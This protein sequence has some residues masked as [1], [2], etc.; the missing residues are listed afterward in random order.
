MGN[1]KGEELKLRFIWANF[2]GI[3]ELN[4]EIEFPK[5]KVVVLYG[6]NLQGKTNL[7]NAI[8]F[9]FLRET[10]RGRKK[11][12]YDDWALPT[13]E[14]IVANGKANIDVVFEHNGAYYKLNREI[15]AGGRKDV[16]TLSM[17]TGW[18]GKKIKPVDF[19][20]FVKERLKAG[21]LDALFAPEIAG[22]FKHLYGRNIDEAITEVFKEVISARQLSRRFI[23]RFEK[24]KSGAEAETTT[25]LEA[26]NNYCQE[27]LAQSKALLRFP[28]FR[29]FKKFTPGK[30]FE[31][32]TKLLEATRARIKS[33]E[34]DE[35]F[36]YLNDMLQKS[37]DLLQLRKAFSEEQKVKDLL[38]GIKDVNSDIEHLRTLLL[39][40]QQVATVEDDI[41]EPPTFHDIE[42]N[43]KA[44][45][46]YKRLVEAKNLH[47]EA[48]IG[49][50]K[51]GANL[52]TVKDSIKGLESIIPVLSKKR[53][54]GEEK[55]AA[56]T[57]LG[58]KAYTLVPI[59]VLTEDPTFANLSEQPIPKGSE[60]ERKHYLKVLEAKYKTLLDLQKKEKRSSRIFS[61]F[62]KKDLA[63]LS[64]IDKE[65][66]KKLD[67]MN[68]NVNQWVNKI[69]THL[70]AF[71]GAPEKTRSVEKQE[72]VDNLLNYVKNKTDK[73]ER[74]YMKSLNEE[75][76][77]LNLVVKTFTSKEIKK[78]ITKLER[79]RLELPSYRKIEKSL[80]TRKE[81]WRLLDE[82]YSD[83]SIVPRMVD[84]TIPL[85]N[86]IINESVDEM[87]LKEAI[88]KTYN[89]IIEKMKERK[90]IKAVAEMSK[91]SLQA[92]VKYK[93][94]RIT[95]P[96][97]AEKAFF[98]LAILTALGQYFGMP[99]LID[100]V[101]NNLD[102]KNL[103]AFFNLVVEFKSE[104]QLQYVLSIKETK[105]FDLEGWV[106][107][108][109]DDIVIYELKDKA[110]RRKVI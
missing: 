41:P 89:D 53:K 10:K 35:L 81:E 23:Q 54:I 59:E 82:T 40:L 29:G 86:A 19:V 78:I 95:H 16:P 38:A 102:S 60:K 109:A 50:E 67:G 20:P 32:M 92:R 91:G 97:G 3:M 108:I 110:L 90:L 74:V 87:K 56:I 13:R 15:S 31:K 7:I 64:Q 49:V 75:I 30:T 85:L 5:G 12:E 27:L 69:T 4:G 14:E 25:I 72:D 98:T 48:K 28:E 34:K 107:D 80:D 21:L 33:L 65:L 58:K 9:A 17:F 62:R 68:T 88:A 42:L 61:N 22:G 57:K 1:S 106:K 44:R 8:R 43:K 46:I 55:Q 39:E 79:E 84:Q 37:K 77:S 104:K 71:V 52:E 45:K 96:G 18:P 73:K 51:Y 100:E 105:D 101:A 94:R 99:I 26:Y 24:L 47:Q 76:N 36:V 2:D 103:P 66:M 70:S 83:L 93:N 63:R 6:E 11:K